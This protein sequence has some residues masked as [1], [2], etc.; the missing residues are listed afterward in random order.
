MSHSELEEWKKVK[1]DED[2]IR[3]HISL[4]TR[5]S[6]NFMNLTYYRVSA[7][8][9]PSPNSFGNTIITKVKHHVNCNS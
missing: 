8:S 5:M 2:F 4:L 9:Y 7:L 6:A 3:A 1:A